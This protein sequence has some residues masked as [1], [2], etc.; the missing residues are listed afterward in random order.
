MW[1]WLDRRF[2]RVYVIPGAVFQ[3][4]MIGGGYGTGREIVEYFTAYGFVGGLLGLSVAF[5]ALGSILALTFEL[6]RRFRVTEYRSFFKLLLGRAWFLF[7]ILIILLFLLV[8]AVL[9]SASG[10]ILQDNFGLPYYVGL[11]LMLVIIGVL[12]FHGREAV[13]KVLTFWS[14]V[15]YAVFILFFAAVLTHDWDGGSGAASV[16]AMLDGWWV[17]GLQYS[18]YN[19]AALPVLL[20]A[21]RDFETRAETFRSGMIGGAIAIVPAVML[22]VSLSMAWP[23]VMDQPIPVYR[24]ME[25]MGLPVLLLVYSIMLFGTFIETGAGML[26]GINDRID[27]WLVEK[28]GTGLT[29]T[30]R[31]GLAI[32]AIVVSALLGLWGIIN[33]IAAGYGTMAWGFLL[34]YVVPLFTVGL[35]RIVR[36]SD[37]AAA[38]PAAPD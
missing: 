20:Y 26:Q 16:P 33:L 3:S 12:T 29:R 4:V 23:D 2:F 18:L 15:L 6:A 13:A 38:A 17:S 1:G 9:A 7:E 34:V 24:M 27:A 10:N 30:A 22:H 8:L 28:R 35:W 19:V 32:A 37:R 14:F 36:G 11:V 25:S 31:A 5:L 21:A